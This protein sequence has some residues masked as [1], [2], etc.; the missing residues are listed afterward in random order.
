MKSGFNTL[1]FPT[2]L[3]FVVLVFQ[4]IMAGK[5]QGVPKF[6]FLLYLSLVFFLNTPFYSYAV[7]T[8]EAKVLPCVEKLNDKALI[9]RLGGDVKKFEDAYKV[10]SQMQF[11]GDDRNPPFDNKDQLCDKK[12]RLFYYIPVFVA[13]PQKHAASLIINE[14]RI[15]YARLLEDAYEAFYNVSGR[16]LEALT[17]KQMEA[18]NW[19]AL[20]NLTEAQQKYVKTLM[21]EIEKTLTAIEEKRK[22]GLSYLQKLAYDKIIRYYGKVGVTERHLQLESKLIGVNLSFNALK[23]GNK[24]KEDKAHAATLNYLENAVERGN[25]GNL[26]IN[27]VAMAH[28]K[29]QDAIVL[30]QHLMTHLQNGPTQIT[31]LPAKQIQ[32]VPLAELAKDG[33][34]IGV[35]VFRHLA[36]G[37]SFGGG[38]LTA[39][40]TLGGAENLQKIENANYSKP[41]ILPIAPKAKVLV[42]GPAL[43]GKIDCQFKTFADAKLRSD[44]KDGAVIYNND[45]FENITYSKKGGFGDKNSPCKITITGGMDNATD[46]DLVKYLM[47]DLVKTQLIGRYFTKVEANEKMV[48]DLVKKHKLAV[49]RAQEEGRNRPTQRVVRRSR[50]SFL[51]GLFSRSST[52]VSYVRPFY[53]HTTSNKL[54]ALSE[55]GFHLEIN[56]NPNRWIDVDLNANVCVYYNIQDKAFQPCK[57]LKQIDESKTLSAAVNEIDAQQPEVG[58]N[59]FGGSN[60]FGGG[61]NANPF[62]GGSNANPFGGGQ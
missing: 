14:R 49:A 4:P 37:G 62:G 36:G 12:A 17:K 26:T 61:S 8:Y 42:R 47:D 58:N 1:K 41:V 16:E 52:R 46:R 44:V 45:L 53:W 28:P 34:V 60:P 23:D 35:P 13:A 32:W 40:L 21:T 33:D 57:D 20:P 39:D 55:E 56:F 10:L 24:T 43:K 22:A 48:N 50:T 6:R 18:T 31:Y 51:G 54:K 9:N 29:E 25:T 7:P 27:I 59:P 30:Y 3:F 11:V 2:S 38:A 5:L 15:K 19:M